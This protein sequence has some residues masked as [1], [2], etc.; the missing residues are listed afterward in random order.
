[1]QIDFLPITAEQIRSATSTD[2]VLKRVVQ[3]LSDGW[4]PQSISPELRTYYEKRDELSLEN[5]IIRWD[6]RVV[7]PFKYRAHLLSELHSQHPGIVRMKALSRIHIW[8]PNIDKAIEDEVRSCHECAKQTKNPTKAIIHPWSWAAKPFDRIHI[9]FFGPFCGKIYL[10][11]VDSHSKWIE[12][13]ILK[14]TNT[15]Y[16]IETLRRWFSQ[17]GLP[18]QLVSDN[19]P[20]FTSRS[21]K[22]L[23]NKME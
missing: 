2:L 9:G 19:G 13:D 17:F 7:I 18:I 21:L 6:L 20:Q 12:V 14:N 3:Y 4:W 10:I 5:G 16:T 11:L 15:Y 22:N 23:Q 8:F 1:M